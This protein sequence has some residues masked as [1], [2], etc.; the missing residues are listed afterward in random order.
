MRLLSNHGQEAARLYKNCCNICFKLLIWRQITSSGRNRNL[1][2]NFLFRRF[3][4]SYRG[5]EQRSATQRRDGVAASRVSTLHKTAH[6]RMVAC[7]LSP[8]SL[9]SL[10]RSARPRVPLLGLA[11]AHF[12]VA[13]CEIRGNGKQYARARSRSFRSSCTAKRCTD[14]SVKRSGKSA[15]GIL[16]AVYRLARDPAGLKAEVCARRTWC[17]RERRRRSS[18]RH[19]MLV[20]ILF[21]AT[22]ARVRRTSSRSNFTLLLLA[23]S[24]PRP[25]S[26]YLYLFPFLSLCTIQSL[27][28]TRFH[29]AR[30]TSNA[31][32][33]SQPRAR[34]G[35]AGACRSR[36]ELHRSTINAT[37]SDRES[38]GGDCR[39]EN[40]TDNSVP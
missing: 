8:L 15:R 12:F 27:V 19:A 6:S 13:P 31:P 14:E 1:G 24:S 23:V 17:R 22:C 3:S 16:V 11:F 39:M 20:E 34:L 33:V 9:G 38:Y 36:V 5:A 40:S 21:C 28:P 35:A 4:P 29:L 18:R 25:S 10:A 30:G 2:S 37:S 26:F 7:R 32:R